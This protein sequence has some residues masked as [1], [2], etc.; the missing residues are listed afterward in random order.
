MEPL[1]NVIESSVASSEPPKLYLRLIFLISGHMSFLA[2]FLDNV[3]YK[4]TTSLLFMAV[5]TRSAAQ[6][7][8]F[9]DLLEHTATL[10]GLGSCTNLSCLSNRKSCNL[11]IRAAGSFTRYIPFLSLAECC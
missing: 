9:P 4:H 6:A 3:I 7:I 1:G 11:K 5:S 10:K 2:L 8:V